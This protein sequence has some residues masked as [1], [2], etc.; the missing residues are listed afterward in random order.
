MRGTMRWGPLFTSPR[1]SEVPCEERC[2]GA[3]CLP[4]R[5]IPKSP[6]KI[7]FF[8]LPPVPAPDRR[9]RGITTP[10]LTVERII[11]RV[12]VGVP[13]SKIKTQTV[14]EVFGTTSKT[15]RGTINGNWTDEYPPAP[16][17]ASTVAH[18][19]RA[20]RRPN[21]TKS[22]IKTNRQVDAGAKLMDCSQIKFSAS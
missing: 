8:L 9:H 3:P 2:V 15:I 21:G 7:F 13:N 18:A 4:P 20:R 16:R 22:G 12:A 1:N 5:E 11:N 6:V 10:T 14:V 19:D 17:A